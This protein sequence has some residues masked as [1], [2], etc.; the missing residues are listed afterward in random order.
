MCARTVVETILMAPVR[1]I[2][3][4]PVCPICGRSDL[5][6]LVQLYRVVFHLSLSDYT[7][8]TTT[9]AVPYE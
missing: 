5:I 7:T 3:F 2:V 4:V 1:G 8:R 6:K 9:L